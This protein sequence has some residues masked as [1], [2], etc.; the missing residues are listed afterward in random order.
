M[1]IKVRLPNGRYIKVD[2]NDPAYAKQRGIEYYQAG[3]TGFVDDSTRNM[4]TE[5]DKNNFDYESGVGAPWLRAKLGAAE[6]QGEKER[7]L[8]EAVGGQGFTRNSRGDLALTPRGLKRLGIKP[9]SNKYVV[10]DESGF[11]FNDF[12]DFSGILGPIVG[13][14]AGSIFTRGKLKPKFPGLKNI[15]VGQIRNNFSWNR[16]WRRKW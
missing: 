6:T 14:I 2:T 10:I 13:S 15:S 4:A 1:A 7:V 5:S 9:T 12:A 8:E 3:E 11:S 16:Y